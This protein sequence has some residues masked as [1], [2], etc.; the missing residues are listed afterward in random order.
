MNSII[1]KNPRI[2]EKASLVAQNN[3]YIFDVAVDATK[4]AVAF[5]V[6]S[7]YKVVP[8]KVNIVRYPSKRVFTRGKSGS[9]GGGKKAYV[10]LKKGDTIQTV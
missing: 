5:A 1:I 2:T 3:T 6:E 9:R 8:V 4:K 10:Y 7:Q